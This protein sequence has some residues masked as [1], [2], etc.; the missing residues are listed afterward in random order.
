[1][2][3]VSNYLKIIV[4]DSN[5]RCMFAKKQHV[6]FQGSQDKH[7][8]NIGTDTR[9]SSQSS[10]Q[11]YKSGL[12]CQGFV[13]GADVQFVA[14]RFDNHR[15]DKPTDAGGFVWEWDV[16]NI[17]LLR[18]KHDNCSEFNFN[19]AFDNWSWFFFAWHMSISTLS[20]QNIFRIR[21]S[22]ST[23]L[24]GLIVPWWQ[25]PATSSKRD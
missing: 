4:I 9:G 8:K 19:T 14:I 1:M 18:P 12:L 6:H 3:F 16:Q 11:G 5:A 22:K 23:R 13:R 25:K 17:V 7:S 24:S 21:S 2:S 15:K 20:S 10:C